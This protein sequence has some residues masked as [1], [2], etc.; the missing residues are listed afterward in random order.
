[1]RGQLYAGHCL[2]CALFDIRIRIHRAIVSV[3]VYR[4]RI[5]TYV[6]DCMLFS[7][8]CRVAWRRAVAVARPHVQASK[9]K[10]SP[11][12]P[13]RPSW[14]AQ[15]LGSDVSTLFDMYLVWHTLAEQ[16]QHTFAKLPILCHTHQP[17]CFGGSV[18]SSKS[19]HIG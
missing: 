10:H 12:T 15:D 16:R 18:R 8:L 4:S 6:A 1:M 14:L 5:D 9:R 17:H 11:T 7:A 2:T 19:T 3:H 13:I